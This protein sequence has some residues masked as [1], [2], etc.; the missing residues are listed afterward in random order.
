MKFTLLKYTIPYS[1]KFTELCN[2]PHY[3]VSDHFLSFCFFWLH[4]LACGISVPP[5]RD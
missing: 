4:L 1:D 2:H 5:T 3:L